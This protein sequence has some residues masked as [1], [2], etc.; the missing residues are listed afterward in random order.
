MK[1]FKIIKSG[2]FYLTLAVVL[3]ATVFVA[4]QSHSTSKNVA[5]IASN[6]S[7]I[8][9][10]SEDI[11]RTT[12]DIRDDTRKIRQLALETRF[13]SRAEIA[14]LEKV[15]LLILGEISSLNKKAES[16]KALPPLPELL[17]PIPESLLDDVNRFQ[18]EKAKREGKNRTDPP[19]SDPW[20]DLFE[21]IPDEPPPPPEEPKTP[22]TTENDRLSV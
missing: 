1:F 5:L 10:Q 14:R 18:A 7:R 2:A 22:K 11:N 15:A 20:G 16:Y 6:T 9:R 17:P 21:S 4:K 12:S 19:E 8:R 3:V 13:E